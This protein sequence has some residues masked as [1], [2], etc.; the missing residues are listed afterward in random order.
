MVL[1]VYAMAAMVFYIGALGVG[2]FLIR[3]GAIRN[4]KVDYKFFHIYDS[5]KYQVPEFVTR[6]GRHFDNQFQMPMLFLITCLTT[7]HVAVEPRVVAPLAWLF[8]VSRL[9][10]SWVHLGSNKII[11]RAA[12]YGIGLL[13]VIAIWVLIVLQLANPSQI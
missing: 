9:L 4:G 1:V 6:Y 12:I 10:H 8:V 7:L 5:N 13:C 3:K 11:H 2:N